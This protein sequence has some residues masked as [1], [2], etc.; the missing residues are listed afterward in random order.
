MNET[1]VIELCRTSIVT[2]VMVAGPILVIMMGV[3]TVISIFQ[4]VTQI[5]EQTLAMVPKVLLV[6]GLSILLAPFMMGELRSFFEHEIADR[7]VAIGTGGTGVPNA[8][9]LPGGALSGGA[10]SGGAFSSGGVSGRG[11]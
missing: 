11:G 5:S 9:N 8:G 7:I 3:G 4:A 6:F 10:F 1:D 2:L